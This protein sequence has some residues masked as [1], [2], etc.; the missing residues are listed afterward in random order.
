MQI[1]NALAYNNDETHSKHL[2]RRTGTTGFSAVGCQTDGAGVRF[3]NLAITHQMAPPRHA[4]GYCFTI[5]L[6][7]LF[8]CWQS[9]NVQLEMTNVSWLVVMCLGTLEMGRFGR[10]FGSIRLGNMLLFG[11]TLRLRR[12]ALAVHVNLKSLYLILVNS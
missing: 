2:S 6:M 9:P 8:G 10:M 1:T 7:T 12:F 11:R 3:L 4:T 5:E